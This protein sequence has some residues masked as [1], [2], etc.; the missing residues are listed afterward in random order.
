MDKAAVQQHFEQ[1]LAESRPE[2]GQFFLARFYGL[3]IEYEAEQCRVTL[4]VQEHMLNPVGALHGGVLATALDVSMGHLIH[5]VTGRGGAT[6][7]MNI[8][9]LRPVTAGKV[10]FEAG[11]LKRGR[12]LAFMESRATNE[13]GKLVAIATATWALP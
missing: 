11:F 3:Q 4:P 5:H 6:V 2:F 7:D 9:Y 12:T 1:A 13:D 10:V 8:Q